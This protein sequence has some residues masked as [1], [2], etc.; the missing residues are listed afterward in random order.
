[1]GDNLEEESSIF[2]DSGGIPYWDAVGEY[3]EAVGEYRRQ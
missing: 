2:G 1:M 3:C